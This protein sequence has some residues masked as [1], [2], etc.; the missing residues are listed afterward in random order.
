VSS[1]RWRLVLVTVLA[2]WISVALV[3]VAAARFTAARFDAFVRHMP[4]LSA[5][6]RQMMRSMMGS[7]EQRFLDDVRRAIWF[8]AVIGLGVAAVAGT[9]T[10]RRITAPLQD[11]AVGARRIGRGDLSLDVPV[12]GTDEIAEVAR[13]FNTMAADLRRAEDSRRELLADIAHELGTPLAVLQANLEGM[14]DGVIEVTPSRLTSLHA[15]T[16]VL[17]RLVRDLRD[18]ALLREGALRLDRRPVDLVLLT[19]EIV[20]TVQAAADEKGVTL[21]AAGADP[22]VVLADHERIAQVLHNL[23]SNALRHTGRGGAVRITV[24]AEGADGRV[25]VA[26]TGTGIPAS[27]QPYVFDRFHRVDRSRSRTTGG[28]GLGLAIV[29]QLVEAHGGR[30]WVRSQEGQGSTFGFALPLAARARVA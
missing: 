30:V 3:G 10:A 13:T 22:V 1:L 7:P 16:D 14:L 28:A 26:D 23:L 8:A 25:E 9:V 4:Q 27:E 17:T 29:K 5:Q 21:R 18:L 2:A 15:Q 6:G 19:R 20:E 24:A 12:T 11:L